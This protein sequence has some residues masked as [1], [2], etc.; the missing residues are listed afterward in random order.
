M[1]SRFFIFTCFETGILPLEYTLG[2]ALQMF[3]HARTFGDNED[4]GN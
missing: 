2:L 4:K 1:E 3:L